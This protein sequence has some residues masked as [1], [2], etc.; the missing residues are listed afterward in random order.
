MRILVKIFEGIAWIFLILLILTA[1]GGVVEGMRKAPQVTVV[2]VQI[3]SLVAVSFA[4][5]RI[6]RTKQ[7]W[8]N[9]SHRGFYRL[10]MV[11]SFLPVIALIVILVVAGAYDPPPYAPVGAWWTALSPAI[12]YIIFFAIGHGVFL[13]VWWIIRGFR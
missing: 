7:K 4:V 11:F 1:F 6:E 12:V 8:A 10:W 2:I 9:K 13:V 3:A 5:L